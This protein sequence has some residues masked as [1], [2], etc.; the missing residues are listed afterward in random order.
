[1]CVPHPS[2]QPT[3]PTNPTPPKN[4]HANQAAWRRIVSLCV[5]SGLACPAFSASL[6]YFDAYRRARLPANLTQVRFPSMD[7]Y[8]KPW[9]G[10]DGTT[11]STTSS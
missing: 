1:M 2:P 10:L 8:K 7:T 4:S 5:A 9:C 6:G 3:N 11:G